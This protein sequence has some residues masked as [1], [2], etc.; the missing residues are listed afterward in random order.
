MYLCVC[1][2]MIMRVCVSRFLCVCMCV[3]VY[4][5]GFVGMFVAV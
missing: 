2:Y 1:V 3:S 5:I 4:R